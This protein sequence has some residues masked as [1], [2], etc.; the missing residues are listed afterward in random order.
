MENNN[1]SIKLNEEVTFE[2]ELVEGDM[3]NQMTQVEEAVDSKTVQVEAEKQQG[4]KNIVEGK[5]GEKT[6][7]SLPALD[8]SFFRKI[9]AGFKDIIGGIVSFFKEKVSLESQKRKLEK[10]ARKIEAAERELGA[11]KKALEEREKRL[12][13]GEEALD[14]RKRGLDERE[15]KL[16]YD[17]RE[18]LGFKEN[19]PEDR[20]KAEEYICERFRRLNEELRHYYQTYLNKDAQIQFD[21]SE[22]RMAMEKLRGRLLAELALLSGIVDNNE[23]LIFK[24]KTESSYTFKILKERLLNE[25]KG[26]LTDVACIEM[27]KCYNEGIRGLVK[28]GIF[29]KN[30]DYEYYFYEKNILDELLKEKRNQILYSATYLSGTQRLVASDGVR[31]DYPENPIHEVHRDISETVENVREFIDENDSE[32]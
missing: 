27:K 20:I 18:K 30:T 32:R 23:I 25:Y 7:N 21:K 17:I 5:S 11:Q 10:D 24:S 15:E 3:D 6:K 16:K 29:Q 14:E 22:K 31:R 26:R 12:A 8:S 1:D 9:K 19:V 13:A 28:L 4:D 2:I